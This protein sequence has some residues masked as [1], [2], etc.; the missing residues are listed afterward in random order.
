MFDAAEARLGG[1]DVLVNNAGLPRLSAIAAADD[2]MFDRS[3]A[4]NLG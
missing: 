1:V 4:R 3:V 2:A